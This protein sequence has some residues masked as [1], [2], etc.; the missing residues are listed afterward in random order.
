MVGF[1]EE[2]LCYGWNYVQ[3]LVK[4]LSIEVLVFSFIMKGMINGQVVCIEELM[5]IL[6]DVQDVLIMIL[7][8]KFLL[9][10]EFNIEVQVVQ[11]FNLIVIVND[12]D[13]GI[14]EFLLVL[15]CCFNIVVMLFFV[16]L[17]EEVKIVEICVV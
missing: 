10:F 6:S 13:K 15:C 17:E 8:E 1:N 11:G 9:I 14:N 4:G 7:L 5:C 3:F 12:R 2:V 16:S